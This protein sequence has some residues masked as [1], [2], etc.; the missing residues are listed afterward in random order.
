MCIIRD[1][2]ALCIVFSVVAFIIFFLVYFGALL[3]NGIGIVMRIP[4]HDAT[5]LIYSRFNFR[6][7]PI[8]YYEH[9]PLLLA[10]SVCPDCLSRK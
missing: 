4:V 8:V 9:L 1:I 10:V 3:W 7:A 2:A 6:C 5:S